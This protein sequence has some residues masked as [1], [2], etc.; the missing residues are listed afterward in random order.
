LGV[1]SGVVCICRPA[2][3]HRR[4]DKHHNPSQISRQQP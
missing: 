3:Q 1:R 4:I 2:T